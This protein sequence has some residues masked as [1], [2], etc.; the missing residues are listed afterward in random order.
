MRVIFYSNTRR[1]ITYFGTK[2][3]AS[4]EFIVSELR[5]QGRSSLGL[6]LVL[7]GSRLADFGHRGI[8]KMGPNSRLKSG[9]RREGGRAVAAR[10]SLDI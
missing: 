8:R 9:I 10:Q 5:Y 4:G 2:E 7:P 1:I 3:D 6:M